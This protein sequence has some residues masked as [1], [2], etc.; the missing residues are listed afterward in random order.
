MPLRIQAPPDLSISIEVVGCQ[1]TCQHCWA[2]GRAYQAMPLE[3]ISWVL[4]E[5]RRFC[6]TRQISFEGYP[7]HEV[8]AHPQAGEVLVLFQQL[9][10]TCFDPLPTTGVP[11]A[12]RPDWREVLAP[13]RSYCVPMLH[14]AF[15]GRGEIHDRMVQRKGAY[16]E[17]LR[18]IALAREAQVH[19]GCN[20]FL[21]TENVSHFDQLVADLLQAGMESINPCVY[22]FT[23]NARGRLTERLR[24]T[25]QEVQPIL[26]RLD[27]L[28]LDEPIRRAWREE[29]HTE[30]WYVGQA[31]AGTWPIEPEKAVQRSIYL[32]CRPNLDVYRGDAGC[33]TRRYGNLRRDGVDEV[34]NRALADGACSHEELWFTPEQLLPVQEVAA[35][36]GDPQ[37]QRINDAESLRHWWLDCARRA[38]RMKK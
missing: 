13:L 36:F 30:S 28:P 24:P 1:T 11:L 17:S 29:T 16:Q 7:M 2:M 9:W 34:L 18:A 10:D 23:P 8:L 15:H 27:A 25:W 5:V 6:T 38:D 21:T 31:L 12:T 32:I 35:R 14:L 22:G 4:H 3:E 37:S 19:T 20:L 33:Y 26:A